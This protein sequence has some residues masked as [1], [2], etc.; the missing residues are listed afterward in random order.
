[1]NYRK[2]KIMQTRRYIYENLKNIGI[3]ETEL[4]A[5]VNFILEN[6]LN[7]KNLY[8]D[9]ELT[10]N[11]KKELDKIFTKRRSGMPVQYILNVADFMGRKFF[12]NE[13]VLIPRP[14]T[15]FLVEKT[16][17]KAS[18]FDNPRILDI[19]T[20]SG[21]ISIM[22]N[23]KILKAH[24]VSCDISQK[25]LDTAK[26]NAE[27]FGADIEFVHSDVFSN[28]NGKFDIIVSNPPYI[29]KSEKQNI[30]KEVL[31]EPDSAL[32]TED[33]SGIEFYE[34]II[35]QGKKYLNAGGYILFELGAGQSELVK[36]LFLDYNYKEIEI[37]KDFENND[38]IICAK[39]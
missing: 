8:V 28:I 26:I 4:R 36:N 17:K 11:T 14:E 22:L 20:G 9:F 33:E 19:G 35:S 6:F 25:A 13:N 1:M 16:I 24:V 39:V 38:R 3:E 31:F 5:E 23:L 10:E 30:Q 37:T 34:K 18:A 27:K 32:Y 15:E 12:V 29:P 7:V 2:I 21:C